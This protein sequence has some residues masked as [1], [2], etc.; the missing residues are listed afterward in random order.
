MTPEEWEIISQEMAE[1]L[2]GRAVPSE[3]SFPDQVARLI[4]AHSDAGNWLESSPWDPFLGH[5]LGD[6][7]VPV[8]I[9]GHGGTAT[10]YA[11]R[12][13][14]SGRV[15]RVIKIL[16]PF[17]SADHNFRH[18]FQR[19]AEVLTRLDHPGIVKLHGAGET[20]NGTLYLVMEF[21]EGR[22]LRSALN[23]GP[24]APSGAA[25]IIRSLGEALQYAHDNEVVHRDLKPENILLTPSGAGELPV[26]LDFGIAEFQNNNT[27]ARTT[28]HLAGSPLYMAP[29]HL[30]GKPQKSSDIYSVAVIIWEMLCGRTPFDPPTPFALPSL[31]RKGVGDAFFRSQ[32]GV[33]V[34]VGRELASALAFQPGKRPAAIG[35]FC[36]RVADA[37]LRS[38]E[39]DGMWERLLARR[40]TRRGVM[41]LAAGSIAGGAWV[42]WSWGQGLLPLSDDERVI[43]YR[44]GFAVDDTGFQRRHDLRNE[45]VPE[46][47]RSGYRIDRY[48]TGSQ[49]QV[50]HPF[51]E[52]QVAA[53]FR[54]GWRLTAKLRPEQGYVCAGFTTPT[55][56]PRFDI[57]LGCIDGRW[58]ATAT[59][60]I[61]RLWTGITVPLEPLD[62][63]QLVDV[64][65]RYDAARRL[66]RVTAGSKLITE[67]YP[68]CLEYRDNHGFFLGVFAD[69]LPEARGLVGDARF[70]I[71]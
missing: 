15:D 31:Q 5:V 10:V 29:E 20:P 11:A 42:A 6:R 14:N 36:S 38:P 68:G 25:G 51:S 1:V 55:G 47:G 41:G 61:H 8:R 65:I 45:V 57:S 22:S 37:L 70:E 12:D 27:P 40:A 28:S 66:A 49:G 3:T 53:A 54:R 33:S 19:E 4:T 56:N 26:L 44:G 64:E 67:E 50:A 23:E 13:L 24:L 59:T 48:F 58:T 18:N 52:R 30:A 17:W 46:P 2:E 35:P 60:S 9:L 63:L 43:A 71:L 39:A 21:R 16:H 7:Y 69:T 32:P 34:L 62:A